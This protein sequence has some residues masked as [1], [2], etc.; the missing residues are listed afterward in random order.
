MARKPVLQQL[1]R[2]AEVSPATV[3]RVGR[4]STHVSPAVAE[5]VRKAAADLGIELQRKKKARIVGFLLS[6]REMLH[7][8]HSLILAGAEAY[9]SA[10][11]YWVLFLPYQYSFKAH[12]RTLPLPEILEH[13]DIACGIIAAGVNAQNL[14][15]LLG[16][17]RIPFAA[18]GNNVTGDWRHKDYD[19]VWF[20]DI[21]GAYEVTRHLQLLDH[22]DIWF[23]ANCQL[24]WFARRC[25]GYR[26]A[27]DEAGLTPHLSE[28]H[29]DNGPEIGYLAAKSLLRRGESVNAIL[30]GDDCVAEGVY[31]ALNERGLQIP[32]GVSVASCNEIEGEILNPPLT[33]IR[34]FPR[35]IGQHLAQ[36]LLDRLEDPHLPPQH[37]TMPTQLLMRASCRRILR[38][39]ES[40]EGR[41]QAQKTGGGLRPDQNM[42]T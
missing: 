10:R 11:N 14:F 17:D 3:S 31:R 39:L 37:F 32:E 42:P 15:D 20:D 30:A 7:P 18:F 28:V 1:A 9:C 41:L 12:W 19:V 5:R 38:V 23:V 4:G 26:R 27:M 13:C 33:T 40:Q 25:Q 34:V 24:P 6:N 22:R 35:Q 21:Q 8:F 2:L 29:S 36:Q 16:H